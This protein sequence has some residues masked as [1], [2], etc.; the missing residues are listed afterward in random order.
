[1]LAGG[2]GARSGAAGNKVLASVGGRP[3]LARPLEVLGATSDAVVAVARA[4][5]R[6]IVAD[7]LDGLDL[8]R[9]HAVVTGGSTR[10][11]SEV[12]GLAAAH[13]LGGSGE[14][15]LIAVH[16]GA[17]P[18]VT[19]DLVE[20][21]YAEADRVGGAWP[22]LAAVGLYRPRGSG[23]ERPDGELLRAQTPQVFR[24]A[25]LLAAYQ[26]AAAAGFEGT[27]TLETVLRH[28]RLMCVA[29]EGD[30]TN[31]KVTYPHDFALAERLLDDREGQ[32]PGDR[33]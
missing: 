17:R 24:A 27:D 23:L 19:A 26:R 5:D 25:G 10:H 11:R 21:L 4:D 6:D 30:P 31:L 15:D 13:D 3:L 16:D 9:P 1:M 32:Q 2:S 14:T 8:G 33:G 22:A 28:G 12:A 7:L 29:V 20:R 18:L